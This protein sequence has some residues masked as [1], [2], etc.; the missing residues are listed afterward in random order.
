MTKTVSDY[1]L[2]WQ[3]SVPAATRDEFI[4]T[5]DLR[6]AKVIVGSLD[7]LSYLQPTNVLYNKVPGKPAGLFS[8]NLSMERMVDENIIK[9]TQYPFVWR[10]EGPVE[11]QEYFGY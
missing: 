5:D 3:F 6:Q 8:Y 1:G 11:L 10:D 2:H 4:T 9:S 7:I